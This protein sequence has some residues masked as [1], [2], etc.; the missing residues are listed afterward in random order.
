MFLG[1]DKIEY[2][3]ETSRQF[4]SETAVVQEIT[5]RSDKFT[6]VGDLRKP[7]GSGPHPVILMI[8]GS[9][10]ATRD[11]AVP[12]T[13]MIATFLRQG[14]A[15]L[16]WDKPGSGESKGEFETGFTSTGRARI[17]VDAIEALSE[18]PDIDLSNVG[19][20]GL[21]QAGWV[22]P[23]AL[24]M[25]DKVTFMI[26]VSGGGEDG[27]EQG[28]YQVSRVIQCNGGSEEE[29][30]T[31]ERYWANMNKATTYDEYREA[32][33]I[34]LDIPGIYENYGLVLNEEKNWSPWP[35][36]WDAF[37]DPTDVL[38][39]T[40]IPVLA[41]FGEMDKNIDPVQG[42]QA[43]EAALKAAGNQ[44]YQVEVLENT[45]HV[46]M[47]AETGCLGEISGTQYVPEYLEILEMW[48]LER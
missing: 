23:M 46:M 8:H 4:G 42:A 2:G 10:G 16:S 34:L 11:G 15:V 25:T 38:K 29:V 19:L 48:L 20:W 28:A 1:C 35:R 32:V 24:E 7:E 21:S 37:F 39:K 33:Q 26:S 14:F 47:P 3:P 36:E 43:Y 12:F 44:H 30:A 5:F 22:M 45:G 31:V 17:I 40:T 13:P 6:L 27:I 9:G 41:F 18:N